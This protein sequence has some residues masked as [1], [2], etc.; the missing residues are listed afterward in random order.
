VF[1]FSR[2]IALLLRRM[3]ESCQ[4][5]GKTRNRKFP[6]FLASSSLPHSQLVLILAH[7]LRSFFKNARAFEMGNVGNACKRMAWN[8]ADA[9]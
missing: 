9:L 3:K 8:L 6:S 2:M 1:T 4:A 5:Q 7:T